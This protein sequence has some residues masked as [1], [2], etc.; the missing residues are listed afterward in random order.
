MVVACVGLYLVDSVMAFVACSIYAVMAILLINYSNL[1]PVR[2][3]LDF[4]EREKN[5]CGYVDY[6][7]CDGLFQNSSFFTGDISNLMT[8]MG[9]DSSV[10]GRVPIWN[11]AIKYIEKS[12]II[13]YGIID[14]NEF[15]RASG[16]SRWDTCAQLYIEHPYNGRHY[17]PDRTYIYVYK[18][19]K[20]YIEK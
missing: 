12:P 1:K 19:S 5:Y 18:Y 14:S 13:G 2:R 20:T 16:D 8:A 9:R 4:F 17:M 7:V 6:M 10:S 3:I 11:A 15:V